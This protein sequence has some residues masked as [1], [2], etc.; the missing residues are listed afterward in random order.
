MPWSQNRSFSVELAGA[1]DRIAQVHSAGAD[2][3]G[4]TVEAVVSRD[5]LDRQSAR[6]RIT[7]EQPRDTEEESRA[8]ARL[9][10][11]L[12]IV[13]RYAGPSSGLIVVYQCVT[14]HSDVLYEELYDMGL[15]AD[16]VAR[17][18]ASELELRIHI[19]L[20][21][22]AAMYDPDLDMDPDDETG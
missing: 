10:R 18:A 11:L 14:G 7:V 5:P 2:Q 19:A 12:D 16:A 1:P 9:L 3:A 6:C 15:E 22:F 17:L 4:V 8:G 21:A 20:A 13:E